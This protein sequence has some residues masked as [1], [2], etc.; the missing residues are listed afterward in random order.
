M[1]WESD[2]GKHEGYLIAEF[3]D[4]QQATGT[5][6]GNVPDDQII[7]DGEYDGEPGAITGQRHITR[8]AAEVIGWRVGCYCRTSESTFAVT[9][10]WA[11]ELLVRVPS[12]AL[13]DVPA[14]RIYAADEDVAYVDDRE[15]VSAAAVDRWQ[16]EHVAG[17][18]A[19]ARI[20]TAREQVAVAEREL[21]AAVQDARA[22]G[23]SWEAIGRA[24]GITRQTAHQ[25]WASLDRSGR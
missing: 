4:G 16:R 5:I 20:R 15:D 21:G 25:R 10:T 24:A 19:L 9:G 11:S 23:E 2:D 14:G 7:V 8:P 1:S 3:S 6:S 17:P 13:E 18:Q 12:A 22:A